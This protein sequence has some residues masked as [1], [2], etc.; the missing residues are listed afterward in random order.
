MEITKEQFEQYL[1]VQKSGMYNMLDDRA[2]LMT[3]LTKEEYLTIIMNY[4]E[5]SK[6]YENE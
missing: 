5:L 6:K 3:E 2:R 1:E 4:D